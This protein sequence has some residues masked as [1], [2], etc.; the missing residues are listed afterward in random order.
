MANILRQFLEFSSWLKT[1]EQKEQIRHSFWNALLVFN[2]ILVSAFALILAI[3]PSHLHM[4]ESTAVI[5]FILVFIP[6]FLSLS[7]YY[8]AYSYAQKK[9]IQ[10]TL[11]LMELFPDKVGDLREK[12]TGSVDDNPS[13]FF[14][15][16]NKF[17]KWSERIS[18]ISSIMVLIWFFLIL[19]EL[20]SRGQ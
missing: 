2:S 13:K 19:K 1:M 16:C 18:S 8:V 7:N 9:T 17:L 11:K 10:D 5:Y 15:R 20:V 12:L 4:K 14:R 6:I 3:A